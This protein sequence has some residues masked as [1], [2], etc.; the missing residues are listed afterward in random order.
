MILWMI[1]QH[2]VFHAWAIDPNY[3]YSHGWNPNMWFPYLHFFM[4]WFFYKS[5]AF[6]HKRT[7]KDLWHKDYH[8]FIRLFIIWS[9][10]GYVLYIILGLWDHTFSLR[11]ALL[12]P[13]KDFFF[14]GFI[15][16]NDPLWFLI[17]LV[18]VRF[19]ANLILPSKE[20]TYRHVR[21]LVIFIVS[22]LAAYGASKYRNPHMPLWV[23]NGLAGLAFFTLGYWLTEYEHKLWLVI[24]CVVGYLLGCIF[25]QNT[26]NMLLNLLM[27]G[28]YLLWFPASLCGIVAFNYLV[29]KLC[30]LR[31]KCAPPPRSIPLSGDNRQ[32]CYAY[33]CNPFVRQIS[34]SYLS[35]NYQPPVALG[36]YSRNHMRRVSSVFVSC[37]FLVE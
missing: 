30:E 25:G 18:G 35:N 29:R 20:D 37:L 8:K 22:A 5:G 3:S 13:T 27:T 36:I 31:D 14:N 24:P 15:P 33:L 32:I 26:V 10:A 21:C 7:I 6:F 16:K 19:V 2:A 9:I 12:A 23:G 4:P 28:H 34:Y 1:I 11:N 17:T